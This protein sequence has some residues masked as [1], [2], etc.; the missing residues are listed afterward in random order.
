M[1]V[2]FA[3]GSFCFALGSAP[4]YFDHIDA[5]G[6]ASTFFVGSIFFTSAAIVQ[7]RVAGLPR[8]VDW[9]A[10]AVQLLGT[11]FFNISTFAATL[12]SLDLEEEVRLIWA[13]DVYG[14][15][16]FLVASGLAYSLVSP[17]FWRRPGPDLAWG[18][19]A[20]NLLGSIA[21][22]V[23]AVAARYLSTTGEPANIRL[24]NLGTFAGAVCFFAGAVLLPVESARENNPR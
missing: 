7:F 23:A 20:L 17:R 3:I 6:V 16:C 13:P 10:A 9:W 12:D 8:G 11:V 4:L 5:E 24:V 18:I 14:S 15:I 2:L 21:F 19:N 1:G 22:G